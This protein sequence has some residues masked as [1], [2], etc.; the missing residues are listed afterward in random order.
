MEDVS[1]I[2]FQYFAQSASDEDLRQYITSHEWRLDKN[3]THKALQA[4]AW[5]IHRSQRPC[6]EMKESKAKSQKKHS[7]VGSD[8]TSQKRDHVS[9]TCSQ[10]VLVIFPT[11][12]KG[13]LTAIVTKF[14]NDVQSVVDHLSSVPFPTDD[15][16]WEDSKVKEVDAEL[17]CSCCYSDVSISAMSQCSDGHLFCLECLKRNAEEKLF[18]Q[19]NTSQ[20][21]YELLKKN[22]R[23]MFISDFSP[24]VRLERCMNCFEKCDGFFPESELKRALN[25]KVYTRWVEQE[26]ASA[27]K[28]AELPDLFSCPVC[29]FSA[30][31]DASTTVFPC[32]VANGGCGEKSCRECGKIAHPDVTKCEDVETDDGTEGRLAVEEAMTK[33]RLRDCTNPNCSTSFYK[34]E[35]CNK[36]KCSQ[37]NWEMCYLCRENI[38]A[39]HGYGHFC[40]VS[41]RLRQENSGP[42]FKFSPSSDR[43]DALLRTWGL[44]RVPLVHGPD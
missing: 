25:E 6:N 1:D 16:S 20:L 26:T 9:E 40:Q 19:N 33:A 15:E 36:M 7:I 14:E 10:Q 13:F 30:E 5:R 18:G 17:E 11:V 28:A 24:I 34:I 39:N 3:A 42:S 32:P 4:R 31:L 12:N 8:V 43:L 44:Q 37:C 38:P 29:N 23:F 35:G 22:K 2:D 41:A 21:K 27:V